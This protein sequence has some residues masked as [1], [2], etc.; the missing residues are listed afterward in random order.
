M[1]AEQNER[2]SRQLAAA[3]T[4]GRIVA[5]TGPEAGYCLGAGPATETHTFVPTGTNVPP[6]GA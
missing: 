1:T 2:D 3:V 6:A 5:Q 4:N